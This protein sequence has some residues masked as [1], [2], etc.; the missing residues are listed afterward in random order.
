MLLSDYITAVQELIHDSSGLDFTNAE[1][2][3]FI[4]EARR[5]VALDFWC[6]RTYFTSLSAIVGQEIYPMTGGVGGAIVTAGG[7]YSTPPSVTFAAPG[8][9]GVTAT[10]TAV[11]A[12]GTLPQPVVQIA[13][14]NWGSGYTSTPTVTF[15]AGSAAA[16][17]VALINVIDI[18]TIS[19]IYPPQPQATQRAMMQW[20]VFS[21]FNAFL[22]FNPAASGPPTV[23]SGYNE[24]NQFYI[25]PPLPD[26][27][28]VLEID[29]F[30]LPNNLVNT[31]DS[32]NQVVLPFNE[33]VQYQGAYKALLKAQ[34]F[35][36]ADYMDKK[37]DKRAREMGLTRLA[38]RK[39]N[40]YQ[41]AWRR[42][43]RG[44]F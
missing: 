21:T 1:L 15:G 3:L 35:D 28:Y 8:G 5:R 18:F 24:Q 20:A 34:N 23:W 19:R 12:A 14:T 36:Q 10:G 2:T 37:Y 17:A 39:P 25:Y 44:Y 32:D 38:P 4:N 26:Q 13:M 40:P 22:R 7:S 9:G 30:V 31:T 43:Q 33:L 42:V 27:S 29:A 6:V 41:N 11:L 16:T